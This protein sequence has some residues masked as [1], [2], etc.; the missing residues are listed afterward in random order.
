MNK[1]WSILEIRPTKNKKEIRRAYTRLLKKYHPEDNPDGF[2]RL[3]AAYEQAMKWAEQLDKAPSND[4]HSA[5]FGSEADFITKEE[6][7]VITD[8]VNGEQEEQERII[9]TDEVEVSDFYEEMRAIYDDIFKRRDIN[10]WTSLFLHQ[11][12]VVSE[13]LS[14][15]AIQFFIENPHLPHDIWLYLDSELSF[16]KLSW[17][18]WKDMIQYD[19]GLTFQYLDPNLAVDYEKYADLRFQAFLAIRDMKYLEGIDYAMQAMEIYNRDPVLYKLLGVSYYV[20]GDY[21]RVEITF[22]RVLKFIPNDVD[23]FVYRGYAY[24]QNGDYEKAKQDFNQ[25]L[26]RDQD[27]IEARRGLG[28]ILKEIKARNQ[29]VDDKCFDQIYAMDLELDYSKCSESMFFF[30]D[31]PEKESYLTFIRRNLSL[32]FQILVFSGILLFLL[33]GIYTM[34]FEIGDVLLSMILIIVL[35]IGVIKVVLLVNQLER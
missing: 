7:K 4:T 28:L 10:S 31:L 21:D 16:S 35:I 1:S 8:E 30:P 33:T 18:P 13:R 12:L 2:M 34:I 9:I 19:L 20:L 26:S 23:A 6:Q 22:S 11:S 15:V 17:F 27:N 14:E 25:A 29:T 24:Y 3:R 5:L 32:L